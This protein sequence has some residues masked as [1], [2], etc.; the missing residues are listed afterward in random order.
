MTAV[1]DYAKEMPVNV[2][3]ECYIPALWEQVPDNIKVQANVNHSVPLYWIQDILTSS[4]PNLSSERALHMP[5]M[6]VSVHP[7]NSLLL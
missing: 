3:V 1:K 7:E 5:N 4:K 2:L 6:L